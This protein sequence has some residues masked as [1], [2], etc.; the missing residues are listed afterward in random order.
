MAIVL[1]GAPKRAV[2]PDKLWETIKA[3][4]NDE[5][6]SP[7]P[8]P[9]PVAGLPAPAEEPKPVPHNGQYDDWQHE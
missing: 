2:N 7:P 6:P 5:A 8:P 1:D 3:Y 9:A 4:G